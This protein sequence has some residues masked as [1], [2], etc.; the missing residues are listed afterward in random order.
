[1]LESQ[2]R[3]SAATPQSPRALL[4]CGENLSCED[5]NLRE[6][7]SFF[8]IPW[9]ALTVGEITGA[10]AANAGVSKFCILSSA[11]SMAEAIRSIKDSHAPLP[12]WMMKAS[13]V[14]IYGFQNTDA[15]K[16]LQRVLTSDS[17]ANIRN[18]NSPQAVMSITSEVP[19]MCGPMSGMR[20][21]VEPTE[22]DLV[23]DVAHQGE[24]FQSII[25]ANGG[26]VLFG[27]TCG[28]VR[29]YLSGCCETIDIRS[30]SAK[31][32][33]V[34]DHFCR[35]VPIVM[36]LKWAFSDIWRTGPETNGCLIVDDPPLKPRYGFL[37]FREALE[38]MDK[39]NFTTTI[40]FIPWNWRRTNPRTVD[41][42]QKRPDRFSLCVHGSD[43]T[44]GEF[45]AR[46]T[47]QL[48]R[49]IKAASGRMEFLLQRTSLQPARIMI[50]PQGAF[51][52]ETGRVLKLNGFVAAV[53]TEVAPSN[54]ARNETTIADLWD[55]AIMK[56]GTFPI[57]TRRYLTHGIEN[58]A[59]D[60]LLGKPCLIVAHHD[61]FKNHGRDLVDF[62][63]KLNSL[64]WNLRWRALSDAICHSFNVRNQ[65][66][67]TSV[68]QMFA[69]NLVMENPS[70]EPR[71][72]VLI[73]EEGDLD[74]VRAVMVNQTAIDFSYD[75]RYLRWRVKLPSKEMAHV[76]V[77]YFDKLDVSPSNDSIG[78][79]IKT[80][81]RRYLSEFR[82]NYL[83]QRDFLYQRAGRIK[84]LFN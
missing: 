2:D 76:R 84:Q 50:F 71:E 16:Q 35:A 53:N 63:A 14:Y 79:S 17:Q 12:G 62:I 65:T 51:S 25:R 52:P 58:F 8:G 44:G 15:C 72:S 3:L 43:H 59:F 7:L 26:E 28:G 31:Y 37:H 83:S 74:C 60:G 36:Y 9:Q 68:I 56:Y 67:G 46:S 81:G 21:L 48:N 5:R 33:D 73:K 10:L 4:L 29:F 19:E 11:P 30:R 42:F 34:R 1:M 22:G 78:Y 66:D 13:S 24:G 32:F 57:F 49:R 55:V 18:L 23:F 27:I 41:I 80:M 82:D 20:V 45:A 40:A 47:A 38:L 61:V 69:E 39:H 54:N 64:K 6:V 77:L 70:T 75:G